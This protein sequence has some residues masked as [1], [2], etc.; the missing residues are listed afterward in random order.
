MA[1]Q[2]REYV[3]VT[4]YQRTP[5]ARPI[6]HV[7]G[8]YTQGKSKSVKSNMK[9]E[10]QRLGHAEKLEVNACHILDIDRMNQEQATAV[11]REQMK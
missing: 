7:Y 8:P 11:I 3:V 6:V 4:R 9:A 2:P 10:A 1:D 5:Q